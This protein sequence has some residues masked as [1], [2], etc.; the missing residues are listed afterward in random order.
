MADPA[1]VEAS[2]AARRT[3][4]KRGIDITQ[5]DI[6]VMHGVC[7]VRGVLSR[8]PGKDID[9]LRAATEQVATL[10]RKRGDIREV[11]VDVVFRST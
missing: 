8:I 4:G 7:H 10:L 2:K 3:F 11:A 9:D 1:D 6:R 5:A